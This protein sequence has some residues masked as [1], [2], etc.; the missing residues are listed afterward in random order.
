[1]KLLLPLLMIIGIHSCENESKRVLAKPCPEGAICK[2]SHLPAGAG[3]KAPLANGEKHSE[4]STT[5][6]SGLPS[7]NQK[8]VTLEGCAGWNTDVRLN[9]AT[10]TKLKL[11][12]NF[13]TFDSSKTACDSLADGP[14]HVATGG[15]WTRAKQ[16]GLFSK[17]VELMKTRSMELKKDL[18]CGFWVGNS[19]GNST[20]G[21]Q[22][23]LVSVFPPSAGVSNARFSIDFF[24]PLK[25]DKL[26]VA[27]AK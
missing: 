1:M 2:D 26:A 27:C 24:A 5:T 18:L 12:E 25:E 16:E 13:F 7:T 23:Y 19:A 10:N 11:L 17:D 15:E 3:S 22:G 9:L 21:T 14:W 8:L 4:N 6:P 20:T